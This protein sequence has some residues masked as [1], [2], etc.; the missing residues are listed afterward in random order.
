M[1][2]RDRRCAHVRIDLGI[3]LLWA[4]E[5]P[6]SYIRCLQDHAKPEWLS[7]LVASRLGVEPLTIDA[8][9]SPFLS[10]P[11]ELAALL[12]DATTTEPVGPLNP[13]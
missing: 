1:M 13:D 2:H 5:L 11:A 10:R 3:G 7:D 8:S 4:A 6:R 9:H 12:V